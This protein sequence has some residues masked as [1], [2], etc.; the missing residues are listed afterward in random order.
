M[1]N[2]HTPTRGAVSPS[3]LFQRGILA[4]ALASVALASGAFA[5]A[6]PPPPKAH[7]KFSGST[8]NQRE[9]AKAL[10][11]AIKKGQ[12]HKLASRLDSADLSK[13]SPEAIATIFNIGFATSQLQ[14][15]NL[16]RRLEALRNGSA[17]FSPD[18]I[19][20]SV[21]A[22]LDENSTLTLAG[23]DGKS[24]VSKQVLA[25][26]LEQSRWGLFATGFGNWADIETTGNAIG[27][28]FATGGFTLGLDY[29]V[30][31]HL[32]LGVTGGYS[33]TDADLYNA[34]SLDVDG[35]RGGLYATLFGDGAYLNAA[36]TG[37]YNSY[38]THRGTVG[39]IASG[40]SD[41]GEFNALL[42][43]GYDLHVGSFTVGPIASL[44][45][46][47]LELNSFQETGSRSPLYFP[48]QNQDSLRSTLGLKA[49]TTWTVFGLAVKPEVRAQWKHEYLESTASVESRFEGTQ[50]LFTVDGPEL[51]RDSLLVDAGV[52]VPVSDSLSVFAYYTGELARDNY[53]SNSVSGGFRVNF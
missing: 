21:P 4:V 39:G 46:T 5:M 31:D 25:P 45:Y 3:Y 11:H 14:N 50:R 2:Q 10:N 42:G 6:P 38:R 47:Y 1:K 32:V 36:V 20:L 22:S 9:V 7:P 27:S 35:A 37:G 43:G 16:E 48:T 49:A 26:A 33:H 30:N 52:D 44:Q 12:L 13:L 23:F 29:R 53:S 24:V 40:D 19:A 28:G 15:V 8:Q 34:G 17:G 41:G 18:G 51:G